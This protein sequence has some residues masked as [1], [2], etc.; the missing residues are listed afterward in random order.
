MVTVAPPKDGIRLSGIVFDRFKENT[1]IRHII[2]ESQVGAGG[3]VLTANIDICCKAS[4]DPASLKLIEQSTVIVP[5]GMPLIW[6]ALIQGD[7]FPER[8]TGSSLIFT[9]SEAAA[10]SG[11]SVYLLGGAPGVPEAAKA[12]LE[13]RYPGLKVVGTDSPPF[14][15]ENS[16]SEVSAIRERI[17]Q[18]MPDLIYVGM[19]FPKQ[20]WLISQLAPSLPS[21]W[22]IGC[23]AAIPFAA[24]SLVRAPVW[25]QRSGLEWAHRLFSEPR[26]L[27]RRYLLDDVPY[28]MG[29]L[30]SSAVSRVTR[31]S[32]LKHGFGRRPDEPS[33]KPVLNSAVILLGTLRID[34]PKTCSAP[35]LGLTSNYFEP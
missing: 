8:I 14:G 26:R 16:P 2:A 19:G 9:L 18:V 25:M 21:A 24:G 31:K 15:F 33:A 32:K 13:R 34:Y 35:L 10:G 23:G 28:A 30:I 7:P 17:C 29:M 20:E 22:F 5:D 3:S 27:V 1:L 11:R 4:R 6:A 12:N